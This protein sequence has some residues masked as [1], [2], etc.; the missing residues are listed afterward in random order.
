MQWCGRWQWVRIPTLVCLGFVSTVYSSHISQ[1]LLSFIHPSFLHFIHPESAS[2]TFCPVSPPSSV[3]VRALAP[4]LSYFVARFP[5]TS[6]TSASSIDPS[7]EHPQLTLNTGP[8]ASH[9]H[10]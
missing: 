6:V 5:L 8:L 4:A 3:T 9:L 2:L 1:Y 10:L 7:G